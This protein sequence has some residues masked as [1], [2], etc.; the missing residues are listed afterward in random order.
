MPNIEIISLRFNLD[1]DDD[2]R[3]FEALHK[4]SDPG[5]RN[6]FLKQTLLEC[7][8]GSGAGGKA[9]RKV[10]RQPKEP[11][12]PP[13]ERLHEVPEPEIQAVPGPQAPPMPALGNITDKQASDG[14]GS[15]NE[16]DSEAAGLV[17][18]FVQ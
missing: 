12:Y 4:R 8:S 18:S 14:C 1:K 9:V 10:R 13:A 17:A 3:L 16:A 15:P 2:R 7:L 6:E 5:K 11:A